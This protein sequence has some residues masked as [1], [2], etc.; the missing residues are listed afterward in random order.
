M[1]C[2]TCGCEMRRFARKGFLQEKV[3]PFFG[4]YPWE[5]P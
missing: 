5:C 2:E 3:Y 4:Y 1:Y